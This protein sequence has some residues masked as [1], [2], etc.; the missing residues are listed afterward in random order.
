MRMGPLHL[1]CLEEPS[2]A[3]ADKQVPLILHSF[4]S[5]GQ[6]STLMAAPEMREPLFPESNGLGQ[7]DTDNCHCTTFHQVDTDNSIYTNFAYE[8]GN[9]NHPNIFL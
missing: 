5:V 4:G 3:P 9:F 6:N 1:K 2:K 7:F 8:K